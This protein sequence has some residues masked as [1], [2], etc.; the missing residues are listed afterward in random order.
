MEAVDVY[1]DTQLRH[2]NEYS[3]NIIENAYAAEI[4]NFMATVAGTEEPR[5]SFAADEEVLR[6]IDQIENSSRGKDND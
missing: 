5:Y 3:Q 6:L 1:L 2:E 4:K